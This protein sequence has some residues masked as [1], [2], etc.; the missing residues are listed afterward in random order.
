M[1][2]SGIQGRVPRADVSAH[3]V[4]IS[5]SVSQ[6]AGE[7]RLDPSLL[8]DSFDGPDGVG[9]LQGPLARRLQLVG[10]QEEPQ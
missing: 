10:G 3:G 9:P 1:R 4:D 8:T 5:S 6:R 7:R 2:K